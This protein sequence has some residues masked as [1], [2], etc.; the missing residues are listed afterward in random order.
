MTRSWASLSAGSMTRRGS[1]QTGMSPSVS[2][3]AKRGVICALPAW[4][5][6][7]SATPMNVK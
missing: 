2:S 4:N 5:P 1:A 6:S 3:R 7:G